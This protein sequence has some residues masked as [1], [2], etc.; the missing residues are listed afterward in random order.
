MTFPGMLYLSRAC[1]QHQQPVHLGEAVVHTDPPVG[2]VVVGVVR[3]AAVDSQALASARTVPAAVDTSDKD[4]P[5]R[6][7][8]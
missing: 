4:A 5:R 7:L 2:E 3:T 6:C 1:Q 8:E